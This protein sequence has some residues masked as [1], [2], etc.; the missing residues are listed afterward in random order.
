VTARH[1][2]DRTERLEGR[3][4][5]AGGRERT[6]T[7][8]RTGSAGDDMNRAASCANDTG[9]ARTAMLREAAGDLR[10][11]REAVG[12]VAAGRYC[13]RYRPRNPAGSRLPG[14]A[15]YSRPGC[16]PTAPVRNLKRCINKH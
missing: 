16:L 1:G 10:T 13:P 15:S 5:P 11:H 9:T 4:G 12:V 6:Q 8:G 14:A 3:A 2:A 7:A